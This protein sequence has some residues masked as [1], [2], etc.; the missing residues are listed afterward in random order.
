MIM[1]LA[2]LVLFALLL[3]IVPILHN[4]FP[5]AY[6]NAKDS[7]AMMDMWQ[8]H[9]PVLLG[10]TTSIDG[11]FQGPAWYYLA[12]PLN[13]LMHF[14]PFASVLTVII[15][16]MMSI[17]LLYKVLGKW[18]AFLFTISA[19]IISTQQTAWVPYLTVFPAILA[20]IA[21]LRLKKKV[22][23]ASVVLLF[24]SASLMFHTE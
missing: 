13:V 21:L 23:S 19:G 20:L 15:L 5:F 1:Q 3:R 11:L 12:L 24:L 22:S 4:N 16:G 14:H 2:L 18:E 10:A 6:D 17:M 9:R 8:T 7:L